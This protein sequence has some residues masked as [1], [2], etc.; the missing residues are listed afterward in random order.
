MWWLTR[1]RTRLFGERSPS[2]SCP[3]TLTH[4]ER[5]PWFL[6]RC[7]HSMPRSLT[8]RH[9]PPTMRLNPCT[10]AGDAIFRDEEGEPYG[11][12]FSPGFQRACHVQ[13]SPV[14]RRAGTAGTFPHRV[15]LIERAGRRWRRGQPQTS[16][17]RRAGRFGV[18]HHLVV[19][20]PGCVRAGPG[21]RPDDILETTQ[22]SGAPG[23]A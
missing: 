6:W 19:D 7:P 17:P 1:T 3:Q 10:D 13:K 15:Q 22:T 2:L 21:L 23:H 16:A 8:P 18:W 14:G 9:H 12:E 5:F 20:R 4:S 11:H